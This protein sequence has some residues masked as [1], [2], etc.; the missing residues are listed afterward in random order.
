MRSK[1]PRPTMTVEDALKANGTSALVRDERVYEFISPVFGGGVRIDGHRKPADPITPVRG[2]AIRGQLRF[3]WRAVNPRKASSL[4]ELFKEEK[5]V[6]GAAAGGADGSAGTL[7]VRV[8]KQPKN[9]ETFHV[10]KQGDKFKHEQ[11]MQG[12][13][14]GAFPLRDPAE[15]AKHGTLHLYQESWTVVFTYADAIKEDIQAALWAWAHFGGLGGRTRRGF[16]AIAQRTPGLL[17]IEEGL[18][19]W[20]GD[21]SKNRGHLPWPHMK[22]DT[23]LMVRARQSFPKGLDAQ[24]HLLKLLR[25]LRQDDI[26]RNPN[27]RERNRPGRSYWPEPDTIRA[28]TG[29]SSA[30]HR[31]A[32]TDVRAAPRAAFGMPIVFH[33]K[34]RG[35]PDDSQLL[36]RLENTELGRLASPL[37]LRPHQCSDGTFEALALV[38]A[39][40]APTDVVFVSQ[41][42]RARTDPVRPTVTIDEAKKLKP[43]NAPKGATAPFTDPLQRYL[44]LLQY[45][46]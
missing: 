16:G 9:P 46:T 34:D 28:M 27:G 7:D 40:P 31:S 18:K 42:H 41:G 3:W 39:H 22:S 10:L 38:L 12:L 30:D 1:I 37:I 20:L 29:K 5:K 14:Y 2:S 17:S 44:H 13:A 43:L 25:R 11:G 24:E 45:G 15:S 23:S 35:D 26:G 33:F 19:R 36:P 32:I 21:G 6:F 4:E 8:V